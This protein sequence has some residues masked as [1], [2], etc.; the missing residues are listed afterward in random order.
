M[1]DAVRIPEDRLP[2]LLGKRGAV[3]RAI[4][5][6]TQTRIEVTDVVTIEGDDPLLAL[7]AKDIVRAIGRG[8]TP[9]QARRLMDDNCMLH[10]VSLD[11]EG[12]RKRQRIFG[13]VIGNEGRARKRIEAETGAK[14]CIRGKTI[15]IIGTPDQLRPAEEAVGELLSGKTHSFAYAMMRKRKSGKSGPSL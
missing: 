3:K 14:I 10:V 11:G 6:S 15:S 5:K 7:K 2:V 1:I 4:E 9:G 8:F 13:R 12:F